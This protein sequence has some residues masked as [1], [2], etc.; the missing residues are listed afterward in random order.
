MKK[1]STIAAACLLLLCSVADAQQKVRIK[2]IT[3]LKGEHPNRL[4]ALGLVVGLAGTGGSGPTTKQFALNLQQKLG[5][6]ADPSL[7][8]NIQRS[9]DKTD[10]MSVVMVTAELPPH[11]KPGQRLD[12][13]VSTLD[14]AKSLQGGLLVE[15]ELTGTDN[16]VYAI[17]AGPV[18]TN[19]GEF[20]GN[21]AT[22]TKNHPTTGRVALGA[23]IENEVPTT[24]IERDIFQL[25]LNDP[26]LATANR[27]CEAINLFS[28]R[29]AVVSDAGSVRVKLP[30]DAIANP[31]LFV[32]ECQ[33]LLV[34]PNT[35]A[36]IVINERT[37]TIVMGAGVKLSQVAITHGNL[38]VSTVETPEV[39]QPA[40]FSDGETTVVPRTSVDV[41]EEGA[42]INVLE[43]NSTVG[44]L[45]TS[46][47][48]LG[49]SPR[50]LS[51]ILQALKRAGALHAE[52]EML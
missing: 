9:Q 3:T 6:R 10:N 46:L 22:V 48:A 21:A 30:A 49:V 31:L 25:N 47:N 8:E 17:A 34:E 40:P 50:D 2:D 32:S 33:Q 1:T 52:I 5:V 37:G 13:I 24:I 12:V 42:V 20:G 45:A 43:Q 23:V 35:V 15:T 29:C 51:T 19:G 44:E 38:I 4:T 39:S 11:H 28:P 27:M 36:R 18:S 7:R 16:V 14:N 41:T 26:D